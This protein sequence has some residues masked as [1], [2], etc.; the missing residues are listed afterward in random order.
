M[1]DDEIGLGEGIAIGRIAAG[2][3]QPDAGVGK[4]VEA[5]QFSEDGCQFVACFADGET[6]A[7]GRVVEAIEV[8]V[9]EDGAVMDRFEEVEDTIAALEGEIADVEGGFAGGEE[10]IV[11]KGVHGR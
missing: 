8:V 11:E 6:H 3:H 1:G 9:G 7:I 10:S 5:T 4:L 2:E